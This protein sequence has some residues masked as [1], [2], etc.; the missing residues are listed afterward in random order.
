MLLVETAR[1]IAGGLGPTSLHATAINAV[2]AIKA[3]FRI[4]SYIPSSPSLAVSW[5]LKQTGR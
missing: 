3:A 4:T 2:S 1:R 5:R